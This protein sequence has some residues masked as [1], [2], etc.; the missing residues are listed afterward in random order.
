METTSVMPITEFVSLERHASIVYTRN[1]FMKVKKPIWRQGLYYR[2]DAIHSYETMK[3]FLRK[4]DRLDRTCNI[5]LTKNSGLMECSCI[6]LESKDIPCSHIFRC[7][8]IE[9]MQSI[10]SPC[11]LKRWIRSVG[12]QRNT[13]GKISRK[14]SEM[15]RY[16]MLSGLCGIMC[17]HAPKSAEQTRSLGR[18]KC[19]TCYK[20]LDHSPSPDY[21]DLAAPKEGPNN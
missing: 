14:M 20:N 7:M 13:G 19:R 6:T 2:I 18:H 17:Y 1:I 3:Y 12:D 9:H 4:Y 15:A 16:G 8:V 11:I 10:L 5:K 21:E